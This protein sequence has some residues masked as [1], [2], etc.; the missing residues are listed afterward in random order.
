MVAVPTL[1]LNE[2]QVRD[3]VMDLE[4]RYLANRGPNLYFALIT[5]SPDSDQAVDE[6]D[7]LVEVCAAL[8][9]G[10]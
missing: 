3:L 8:D 9:S 4:I 5:D 1:L 7:R 10:V 2:S 6:K